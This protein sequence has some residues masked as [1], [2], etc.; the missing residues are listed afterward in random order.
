LT[1]RNQ[2]T[3]LSRNLV[4]RK[5]ELVDIK[6]G[7]R[8]SKSRTASASPAA[9]GLGSS[10]SSVEGVDEKELQSLQDSA[11]WLE[12]WKADRKFVG[13]SK[14]LKQ[15]PLEIVE[16]EKGLRV[17]DCTRGRASLIGSAQTSP[18]CDEAIRGSSL[19]NGQG[20]RMDSLRPRSGCSRRVRNLRRRSP[21]CERCKFEAL[22][23][24]FLFVTAR[25]QIQICR[26]LFAPVPPG[27]LGRVIAFLQEASSRRCRG[28]QCWSACCRASCQR[29]VGTCPTSAILTRCLICCFQ[30]WRLTVF[31]FLQL[32][33]EV[34]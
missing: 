10:A 7:K 8:S 32:P 4:D 17:L 27:L 6:A 25:S 12:D 15:I 20:S 28:G 31:L 11:T 3:L 5:R 26:F 29:M 24:C 21:R 30:C 13:I 33:Y 34:L 16:A 19:I 2:L 14:R 23:T 18:R 1:L 9:A 22:S